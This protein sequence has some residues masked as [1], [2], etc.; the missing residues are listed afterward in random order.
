MTLDSEPPVTVRAQ[1]SPQ[2][3]E[4][5][6]VLRGVAWAPIWGL[7]AECT[8]VN[9]EA[10]ETLIEAGS[11]NTSL[12]LLL[13]GRLSVRIAKDDETP[14]AVLCRGETVGEISIIDQRPTSAWV[15]ATEPSRLLRI[16]ERVFWDIVAS[17]HQFA[18]NLL[19]L[20]SSRLRG[21]IVTLE[22]TQRLRARWERVA[23]FDV[24]TGL[25]NRRWFEESWPRLVRRFQ[26]SGA[27]LSVL[28]LDIDHFKGFNDR[29]G[30][31]TGDL[32]LAGVAKTLVGSMRPTDIVTRLG[33]EELAVILPETALEGALVAA[34]RIR[35]AVA[36]AEVRSPEGKLLPQVTISIGAACVLA[37]DTPGKA[38]ARADAA[39]YQA[40]TTG[41]NRVVAAPSS[42]ADNPPEDAL[43][44]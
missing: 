13:T 1:V 26:F 37:T 4:D 12:Y 29:F 36:D 32:V 41:R 24:L 11:V 10:N 14:V 34:E 7:L 19:L 35:H 33:G 44:R 27:P 42:L 15:I 9:L 23:S 8:L 17:S 20:L 5:L 30:H 21:N 31:A 3:L 18:V 6:G 16:D 39:L 2:E 28:M 40:K 25:H 22:H 43:S 38:L